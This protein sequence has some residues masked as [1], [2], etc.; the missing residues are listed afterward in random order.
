MQA[1]PSSMRYRGRFPMG[2]S[3]AKCPTTINR[4]GSTPGF[5]HPDPHRRRVRRYPSRP[6]A[7]VF[8]PRP[9]RA[10]RSSTVATLTEPSFVATKKRSLEIFQREVRR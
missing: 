5:G 8:E 2:V 7:Q 3:Y 4:H 1:R 6:V 9:Q 10:M